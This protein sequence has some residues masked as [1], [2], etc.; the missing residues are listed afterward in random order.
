M[1]KNAQ[2]IMFS[3]G[4]KSYISIYIKEEECVFACVCVC[5]CAH[6]IGAQ[7]RRGTLPECQRNF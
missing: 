3:V 1:L 7:N 5:V 6:P 4:L 2:T